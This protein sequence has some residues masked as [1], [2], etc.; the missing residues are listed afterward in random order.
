MRHA[1]V[2]LRVCMHICPDHLI[3]GG[4]R[5]AIGRLGIERTR[6][7]EMTSSRGEFTVDFNSRHMQMRCDRYIT[8]T[9][10]HNLGPDRVRMRERRRVENRA[11]VMTFSCEI[12]YIV[13]AIFLV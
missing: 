6:L 2:D 10:Q 8:T 1:D 7:V 13:R 11:I 12:Y 5:C 3:T 4:F 9:F